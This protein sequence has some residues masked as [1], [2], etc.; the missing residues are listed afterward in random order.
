MDSDPI[1]EVRFWL[2]VMTDARRTVFCPPEWE[3]RCKGYVDARGLGGLIKVVAHPWMPP[4]QLV[5]VDENAMEASCRQ[6]LQT[7]RPQFEVPSFDDIAQQLRRD[8]IYGYGRYL[9][10]PTPAPADYSLDR[11]EDDGGQ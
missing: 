2:Q 10:R 5:V 4:N 1:T 8:A 9:C 3:S 11:W 7:F 6:S